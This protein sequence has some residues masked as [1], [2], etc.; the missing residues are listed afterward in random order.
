MG[1]SKLH[2]VLKKLR[3]KNIEDFQ[4]NI[5]PTRN[6]SRYSEIIEYLEI[7]EKKRICLWLLL[8][9]LRKLT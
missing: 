5:L 4:K 6:S 3:Y 8:K 1:K 9:I 7:F 2:Q